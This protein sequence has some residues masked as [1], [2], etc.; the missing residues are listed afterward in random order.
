MLPFVAVTGRHDQ[1]THLVVHSPAIPNCVRTELPRRAM[2][3]AVSDQV[4][5]VGIGDVSCSNCVLRVEQYMALP[6]YELP[7]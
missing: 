1:R 5:A 7:A 4:A 3:G 2:C 6:A